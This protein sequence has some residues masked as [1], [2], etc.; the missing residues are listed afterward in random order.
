VGAGKLPKFGWVRFRWSRPPAG[1]TRSAT[2]SRDGRHWFI[3]FLVED[4]CVTPERHATPEAA[5]GVDRGVTVAVV[6]SD[7]TMRDREF[8]TVGETRRYRRLQHRLA[9]QKRGS[10]NRRKTLDAM[11]RLKR[12]E[13]DRRSDFCTWSANRLATRH[14]LVA[15]EDLRTRTM[16]ASAK[17]TLDQPGRNVRAK[18]GLNRSILDKGWYKLA[19]ALDNV[20]RYTGTTI[21]KVPAAYTSQRCSAC[22]GVD[23]EAVRAK[24]CFGAPP[25]DT[26]R[27]RT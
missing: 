14:G 13:R 12:R 27:T 10:A 16:T 22:C 11:R 19:L 6:C 1:I 21:V 3:S 20:A 4:G 5:V 18:A 2:V 25:A 26:P 9:R 15:I 23:P 17:G 8:R 7:G 24:R